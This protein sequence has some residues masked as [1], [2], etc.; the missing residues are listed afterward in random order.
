MVYT[1]V[2][3]H[4]RPNFVGALISG[5]GS[6][7][8]IGEQNAAAKSQEDYNEK[9]LQGVRE[10]NAQNYKI[11]QEQLAHENA[12]AL[13]SWEWQKEMF[14]MQN[15]QQI[16]MWNMQNAYNDPSAQRARWED[17]GFSPWVLGQSG[18]AGTA[19]SMSPGSGSSAPKANTPGAPTMQAP[20]ALQ[21]PLVESFN[22]RL[23][24]FSV[25]GNLALG[26]VDAYNSTRK[27]GSDIGVNNSVIGLNNAS[28]TGKDLENRYLR[29]TLESRVGMTKSQARLADFEAKFK[30]EHEAEY[31]AIL[32]GQKLAQDLSNE[33]QRILNEWLPIEK[34]Q[35]FCINTVTYANLVRDGIIKEQ[36][37]INIMAH[38]LLINAQT[39]NVNADTALKNAQTGLVNAQADNERTKGD[40][41][42]IDRDRATVLSK[43]MLSNAQMQL[44]IDELNLQSAYSDADAFNRS[45]NGSYTKPI[46][47]FLVHFNNIGDNIPLIGQINSLFRL[48][49]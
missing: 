36:Q 1:N 37:A 26:A 22:Q 10:T 43:Q 45:R 5:L 16:A 49:K 18:N 17:A 31:S 7:L 28:I 23:A 8:G 40:M 35:Q 42:K 6:V 2:N 47:D 48:K 12:S 46:F 3:Q 44:A 41:L 29:D 39:S 15:Q 21:S 19:S 30:W 13:Q 33:Q 14:G 20:Q 32:K 24:Q 38:T 9:Y 4:L 25:I 11:W 27:T 34:Q